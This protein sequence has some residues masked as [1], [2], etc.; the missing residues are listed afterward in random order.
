MYDG[1]KEQY[2]N[3]YRHNIVI[4]SAKRFCYEEFS[5]TDRELIDSLTAAQLVLSKKHGAIIERTSFPVAAILDFI[6][7]SHVKFPIFLFFNIAFMG[8]YS[9]QR[10]F[11]YYT[12]KETFEK[13]YP[14][15]LYLLEMSGNYLNRTI[16]NL[17]Q[18]ID[19]AVTKMEYFD[20]EV[21]KGMNTFA[22]LENSTDVSFQK[23]DEI[24]E[25]LS[26]SSQPPISSEQLKMY[27]NLLTNYNSVSY[28]HICNDDTIKQKT[29]VHKS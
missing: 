24:K 22:I 26:H 16:S 8:G 27:R 4:D 15:Q 5:K 23:T 1:K 12:E 11:E 7:I 21:K 6:F 20:C 2:L 9:D 3:K 29:I 14:D 28:T 19:L 13:K 18:E 10:K 17:E 25:L